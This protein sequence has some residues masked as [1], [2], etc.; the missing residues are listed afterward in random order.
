MWFAFFVRWKARIPDQISAWVW[1]G[2]Y[3]PRSSCSH[4]WI[5]L[6]MPW[7]IVRKST[8]ANVNFYAEIFFANRNKF[9]IQLS[10]FSYIAC[11]HFPPPWSSCVCPIVYFL[12]KPFYSSSFYLFISTFHSTSLLR[13]F[14]KTPTG[15]PQ[16]KPS[17]LQYINDNWLGEFVITPCEVSLKGKTLQTYIY[18]KCSIY[19]S[20][21]ED[22]TAGAANFLVF[23]SLTVP[24]VHIKRTIDR[25]YSI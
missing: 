11:F 9:A 22:R 20:L 16:Q 7:Y 3:I 12:K 23:Y 13:I 17:K 1:L 25:R 24:W 19:S 21:V 2:N 6:K 15:I 4:R 8:L 5:Y 18:N 14:T 10:W